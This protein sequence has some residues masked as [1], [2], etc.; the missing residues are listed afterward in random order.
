MRLLNSVLATAGGVLSLRLYLSQVKI[1]IETTFPFEEFCIF[2]GYH[3][4]SH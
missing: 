4:Q 2:K 1:P 3:V